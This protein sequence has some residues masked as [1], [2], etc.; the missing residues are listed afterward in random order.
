L[1]TQLV[2]KMRESKERYTIKGTCYKY[3]TLADHIVERIQ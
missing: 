2:C 1:A 3:N